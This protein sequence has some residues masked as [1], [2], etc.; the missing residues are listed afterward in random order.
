M[1]LKDLIIEQQIKT[2]VDKSNHWQQTLNE[3]FMKLSNL[4]N[5]LVCERKRLLTMYGTFNCPLP[6][7]F[8]V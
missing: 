2:E 1:K 8:R 4:N 7:G 3:Y 5:W 6:N